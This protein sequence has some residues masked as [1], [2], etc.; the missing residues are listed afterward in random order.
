MEDGKSDITVSSV[1]TSD[2]SSFDEEDFS[3]AEEEAAELT[4]EGKRKFM[5]EKV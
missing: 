5:N 3:A 4:E 1:H 2:L